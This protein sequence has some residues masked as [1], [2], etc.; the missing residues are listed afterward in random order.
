M[1]QTVDTNILVYASNTSAQEHDRAHLLLDHLAGGPDLVVLLYP[2]ILGYLRIVTNH[3]ILENPL[4]HAD[5]LQNVKALAA[6][7]HVRLAGEQ[8]GFLDTYERVITEVPVRGNLIP[9]AHLVALMHQHGVGTVWTRDRD[10]RKFDDILVRN[11]FTEE[12]QD[13]FRRRPPA[14]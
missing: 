14:R 11:P 3:R 6:R 13:G 8:E 4:T 1:S 5:A 12:F 7:P 10:L 9:D 2:T